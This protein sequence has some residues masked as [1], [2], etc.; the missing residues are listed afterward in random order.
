[1]GGKEKSTREGVQVSGD[2]FYS[3]PSEYDDELYWA[4]VARNIGWLGDTEDEARSRQ[5]VLRDAVVGVAGCGG[6]G[7]S[8]ADRLA[9]LGVLHLRIA[10]L[11]T[12]EYSNINRQPGRARALDRW[13]VKDRGN[14]H[15]T[16]NSKQGQMCPHVTKPHPR[17]PTLVTKH[18][19]GPWSR[20]GARCA[21]SRCLRPAP[22]DRVGTAPGPARP[23]PTARANRGRLSNGA[24][25]VVFA[26]VEVGGS[27]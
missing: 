14:N 7:G 19:I 12:F 25:L 26:A 6:I 23:A 16:P 1:V 27:G 9:R 4:R 3:F 17:A 24:N 18:A 8:M 10:D 20:R 22:G 5:T 2:Y 21:G 13:L 15:T 11:D